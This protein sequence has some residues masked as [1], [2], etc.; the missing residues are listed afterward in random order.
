[1]NNQRRKN[2]NKQLPVIPTSPLPP[3]YAAWMDD[4]FAAPIPSESDATCDECAMCVG[5]DDERE[6]SGTFFDPHVKCCSYVPELPNYLVGGVLSDISPASELGRASMAKRLG[7]GVAVTPLGIGQPPAFALIY[8]RASA[9][10]FGQ[11]HTLIC[12]HF[13]DEGG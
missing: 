5:S 12:P 10:A 4:L 7:A 1:M 2:F 11:S 13:V 8:E 6:T 9:S 3:L